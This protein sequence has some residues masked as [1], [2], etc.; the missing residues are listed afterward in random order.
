ELKLRRLREAAREQ[1]RVQRVVVGCERP[2][3]HGRA[4]AVAP[5]EAHALHTS[6]VVSCLEA[7]R[8][9][10]GLSALP[11]DQRRIEQALTHGREL[12]A[13]SLDDVVAERLVLEQFCGDDSALTAEAE[14]QQRRLYLDGVERGRDWRCGRPRRVTG[15]GSRVQRG[16]E[17]VRRNDGARIESEIGR[18]SCR[19]G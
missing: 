9:A 8:H 16:L 14:A 2:G 5:C 3:E 19:E 1:R 17:A 11:N 7:K 4:A 18:A 12:N 10:R 13:L 6:R 15:N